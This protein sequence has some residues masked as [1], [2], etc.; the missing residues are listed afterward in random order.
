MRRLRGLCGVISAAK[1]KLY[2]VKLPLIQL[3]CCIIFDTLVAKCMWYL[4]QVWRAG[5]MEFDLGFMQW[6]VYFAVYNSLWV[7]T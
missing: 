7:Y 6:N 1:Y 5:C 2:V 4:R 3:I